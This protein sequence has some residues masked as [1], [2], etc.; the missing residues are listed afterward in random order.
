MGSGGRN[1][2]ERHTARPSVMSINRIALFTMLLDD[3]RLRGSN[4]RPSTNAEEIE[5][6]QYLEVCLY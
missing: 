2:A 6:H 3:G 4:Q 1:S 5:V